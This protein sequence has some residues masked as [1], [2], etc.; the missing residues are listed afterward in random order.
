MWKA[1][2]SYVCGQATTRA[3]KV[4]VAASVDDD[5]AESTMAAILARA[6]G[7]YEVAFSDFEQWASFNE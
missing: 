5:A 4:C 7:E 6:E 2:L 1:P 3:A